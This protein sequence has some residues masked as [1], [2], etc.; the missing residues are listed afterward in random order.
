MIK[1][2]YNLETFKV[3]PDEFKIG[4]VISD[5]MWYSLPK[6]RKL[7][8]VSEPVI[9]EWID[10]HLENGMLVQSSTG[11]KSY[12]FTHESIHQWY[13]DN[14]LSIEDQLVDFLFPPRIWDDLTETE[15]FLSAP[16]REIGIVSFACSAEV[17]AEVIQ[18]LRG[19]AKVQEPEPNHY[20]AHCLDASEVKDIVHEVFKRHSEQN[21]GKV[22]SRSVAKRRE[23]VDF[24][25]EFG[26]GLVW[27][28]KNFGKTLVRRTM[29]TI[30]IF[31][32]EQEDRD[33]QITIWV[34]TAI[35]KFDESTSVPFSGYLNSVLKRWPYDLPNLHLG[36]ELSTFQRERSRAVKE[37][38]A[39][40]E[41]RTD[42]TSSEI[43]QKMGVEHQTFAGLEEKHRIWLAARSATTLTWS[44]NGQEKISSSSVTSGNGDAET[45]S[46]D[47]ALAH[48]ISW[49]VI[50]SAIETECFE[51]AFTVID[52][53]DRSNVSLAKISEVSDDFIQSLGF[54][55]GISGD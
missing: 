40:N 41:D 20:K 21:I 49:A 27:F 42:F 47:I 19:V 8:K 28:Y 18:A 17:A 2:T 48:K 34:L 23:L 16:L 3:L 44:E 12:R 37:L 43:S 6:W 50:Q 31:L 32:P 55:L 29:D 53:I 10:R 51:D 22:Y 13:S 39:L 26:H 33:T 36:D 5:G 4:A 25:P 11:A 52:Q 14:H 54:N 35:S 38:R 9:T 24:T 7:A 1:A 46:N 45:A 15:G 30:S